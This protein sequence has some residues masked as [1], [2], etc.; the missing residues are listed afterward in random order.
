MAY[1]A[2]I[3]TARAASRLVP[4]VTTL[5]GTGITLVGKDSSFEPVVSRSASTKATA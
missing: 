5:H 2:E 3:L 4:V 1:T